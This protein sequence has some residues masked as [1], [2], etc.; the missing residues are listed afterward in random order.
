M[1]DT[2]SPVKFVSGE[3]TVG[4]NPVRAGN[5]V[6]IYRNGVKPVKGKPA[7]F[8]AVGQKVAVVDVNGIGKIGTWKTGE[9]AEGTYLLK[10]VLTDKDGV[11][12]KVSA[13]VSVAK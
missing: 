12:V 2:V 10:G 4:P 6:S 7:V 5:D 3:V 9:V 13:L 11:K 1:P 8:D